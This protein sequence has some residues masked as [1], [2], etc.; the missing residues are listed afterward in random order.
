MMCPPYLGERPTE[1]TATHYASGWVKKARSIWV[2][3]LFMEIVTESGMKASATKESVE[4]PSAKHFFGKFLRV[5]RI[6]M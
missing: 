2:D 5:F 1:V 4:D 3:L 6:Y